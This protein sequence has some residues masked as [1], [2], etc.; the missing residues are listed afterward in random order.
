[1][2][3]TTDRTRTARDGTSLVVIGKLMFPRQSLSHVEAA[4]A[5]EDAGI[6]VWLNSGRREWLAGWTLEGFAAI[7]DGSPF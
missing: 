3:T 2:A 6:V 4:G 5:E 7:Y 1:M